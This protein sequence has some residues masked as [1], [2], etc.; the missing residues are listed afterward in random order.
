MAR[1][2]RRSFTEENVLLTPRAFCESIIRRAEGTRPSY[3][4]LARLL[5]DGEFLTPRGNTH[6][7]PAQVQQLLQGAYDSY[8]AATAKR[9]SSMRHGQEA[10]GKSGMEKSG[11]YGRLAIPS[12]AV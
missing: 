4:V 6:W 1:R 3:P 11:F 8:Y 12:R 2:T 9:R 7:W 10:H 5:R